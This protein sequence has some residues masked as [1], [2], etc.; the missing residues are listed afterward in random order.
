MK[1]ASIVLALMYLA[2]VIVDRFC[3]S[4]ARARRFAP[5]VATETM[6]IILTLALVQR[7]SDAGTGL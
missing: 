3:G 4:A 6:G 7:L 2:A 1:P 5:I